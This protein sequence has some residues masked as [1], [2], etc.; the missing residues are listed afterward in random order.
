MRQDASYQQA[1]QVLALEQDNLRRLVDAYSGSLQSIVAS[2]PAATIDQA[3]AAEQNQMTA[4][5][6]PRLV[7][8]PITQ[9]F[10]DKMAQGSIINDDD[11]LTAI[12]AVKGTK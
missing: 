3:I 2:A 10:L 12:A 8:V 11:L 9:S 1:M 4:S 7:F 5:A 6:D